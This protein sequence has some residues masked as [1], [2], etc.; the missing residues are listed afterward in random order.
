MSQIVP[1]RNYYHLLF[2]IHTYTPT[3][4]MS[5]FMNEELGVT[6]GYINSKWQG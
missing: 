3:N 1:K 5:L 4:I 2:K 6:Q